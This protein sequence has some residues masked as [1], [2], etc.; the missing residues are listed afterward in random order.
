MVVGDGD[1]AFG[2]RTGVGARSLPGGAPVRWRGA[3][4]AGLVGLGGRLRGG[5]Q[6]ER[7][8]FLGEVA[9]VEGAMGEGVR[10]FPLGGIRR[11]YSGFALLRRDK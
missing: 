2:P 6:R 5:E 4:S 11:G 7:M 3:C 8:D 10:L 1:E 9:A